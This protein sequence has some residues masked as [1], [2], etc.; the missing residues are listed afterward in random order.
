MHKDNEFAAL[1]FLLFFFCR[2]NNLHNMQHNTTHV[3]TNI[4][5]EPREGG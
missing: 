3:D 2:A 5:S 4:S 1:S